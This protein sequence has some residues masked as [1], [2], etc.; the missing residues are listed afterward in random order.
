MMDRV[1]LE[2]FFMSYF[3]DYPVDDAGVVISYILKKY[4]GI[5]NDE[6]ILNLSQKSFEKKMILFD[7]LYRE[8][9][10]PKNTYDLFISNNLKVNK[11]KLYNNKFFKKLSQEYKN[12]FIKIYIDLYEQTQRL[13]SSRTVW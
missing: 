4:K 11:E 6:K 10:I 12:Y 13:Q 3:I 7:S 5:Y 8:K 2:S 9:V 1:A